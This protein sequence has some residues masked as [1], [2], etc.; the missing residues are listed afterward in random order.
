MDTKD[1]ELLN[2][3]IGAAVL[4][5][6]TDGEVIVAEILWVSEEHQDMIYDVVTSSRPETYR[7][8]GEKAAYLIPFSEVRSVEPWQG[9]SR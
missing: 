7:S 2:A 3:S 5:R 6:C 1:L 9:E 4:L 8:T